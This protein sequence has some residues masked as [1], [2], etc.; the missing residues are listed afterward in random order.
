[1]IPASIDSDGNPGIF[2]EAVA[3]GWVVSVVPGVAPV[4]VIV[5][6]ITS[7]TV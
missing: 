5:L 7:V 4:V 1:M 2:V 6:C 3:V